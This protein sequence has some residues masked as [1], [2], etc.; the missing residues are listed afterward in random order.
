MAKQGCSLTCKEIETILVLLASTDTTIQAIAE[1]MSCS[2]SAIV[3]INRKF[4][5]RTYG[6]RRNTWKIT[7]SGKGCKEI[8]PGKN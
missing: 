7:E 5:V 2:R 4:Q 8:L 3:A 6:G 1:R